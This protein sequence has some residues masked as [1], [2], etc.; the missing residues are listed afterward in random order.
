[1]FMFKDCSRSECCFLFCFGSSSRRCSVEHIEFISFIAL[2]DGQSD[3]LN[4]I[5]DIDCF[6]HYCYIGTYIQ[7]FN[8]F[9]D[10][11]IC[12]IKVKFLYVHMYT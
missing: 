11:V 5:F 6:L 1:M 7:I 2:T 10:F 3:G 4:C 8:S 12:G 9:Y